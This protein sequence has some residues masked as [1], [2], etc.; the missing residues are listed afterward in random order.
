[1]AVKTFARKLTRRGAWV[2]AIV[3]LVLVLV[4][5]ACGRGGN[6]G[7]G[8]PGGYG[9]SGATGSTGETTSVQTSSASADAVIQTDA[10]LNDIMATLD[11]VNLDASIDL[12]AQ[13][14]EGSVP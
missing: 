3:A 5:A 8:G 9:G 7:A 2:V 10:D 11:S 4:L 14:N 1:M 12:S 6:G 13:D